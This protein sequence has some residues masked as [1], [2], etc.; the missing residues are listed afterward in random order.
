MLLI[1]Q[2]VKKRKKDK[3]IIA[4]YGQNDNLNLI[5]TTL[6]CESFG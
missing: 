4:H 2:K 6:K 1:R 3:E 5:S